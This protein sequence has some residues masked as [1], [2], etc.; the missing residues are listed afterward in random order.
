MTFSLKQYTEAWGHFETKEEKLQLF[1]QFCQDYVSRVH[2]LTAGEN[3][4]FQSLGARMLEELGQE[5]HKLMMEHSKALDEK[6]GQDN[7]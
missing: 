5:G 1:S 6:M 4:A 2:R 7:E 3:A